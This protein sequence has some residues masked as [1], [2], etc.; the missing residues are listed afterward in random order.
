MWRLGLIGSPHLHLYEAGTPQVAP[1]FKACLALKRESVLCR[2]C[3]F[4]QFD[5]SKI[6]FKLCLG[7][8]LR[9]FLLGRLPWTLDAGGQE[10]FSFVLSSWWPFESQ[11]TSCSSRVDPLLWRQ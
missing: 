4:D 6:S 7:I 8:C 5:Y 10:A 2:K 3:C 1:Q 9:N 11:N